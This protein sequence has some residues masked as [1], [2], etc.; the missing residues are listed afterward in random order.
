MLAAKI[1]TAGFSLLVIQTLSHLV[2]C[3]ADILC[4]HTVFAAVWITR[5]SI[6]PRQL[7]PIQSTHTV[8]LRSIL[9]LF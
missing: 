1:I 9:I 5:Q 7:N 4:R 8:P 6:V 3:N 2:T